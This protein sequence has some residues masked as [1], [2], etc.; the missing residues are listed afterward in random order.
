[1]EFALDRVADPGQPAVSLQTAL[2]QSNS[3]VFP[4]IGPAGGSVVLNDRDRPITALSV[5]ILRPG[6]P[7]IPADF[8]QPRVVWDDL[9]GDGQFGYSNVFRR[10]SLS[11]DRRTITF[12]Q[13]MILPGEFFRGY[14]PEM[15]QPIR[16]SAQAIFTFS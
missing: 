12:D 7:K 10:V 9:T 5:E 13:G 15:E 1:V 14:L 16:F 8:A 4:P 6:D 11:Q 2:G 3:V